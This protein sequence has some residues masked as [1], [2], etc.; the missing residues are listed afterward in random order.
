MTDTTRS[1]SGKP[2]FPTRDNPPKPGAEK[3]APEKPVTEETLDEAIE[4]SFPASD[5]ISVGT[6]KPQDEH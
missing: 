4:E 6:K 3:A 1:D 2:P 5:P